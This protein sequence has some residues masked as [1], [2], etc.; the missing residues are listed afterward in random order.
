MTGRIYFCIELYVTVVI[1]NIAVDS[2]TMAVAQR[3]KRKKICHCHHN[4]TTHAAA[5]RNYNP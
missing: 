3:I 2:L 5:G 4:R 1:Y